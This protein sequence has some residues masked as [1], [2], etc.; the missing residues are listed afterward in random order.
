MD[1]NQ[2]KKYE[3]LIHERDT[4]Q[5]VFC[6]APDCPGFLGS[7]LSFVENNERRAKCPECN[8]SICVICRNAA[9]VGECVIGEF[10]KVMNRLGIRQ[11]PRCG[12]A[13]IK[14]GGCSHMHCK[15]CG[16]HYTWQKDGGMAEW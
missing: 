10:A 9:H 2:A 5:P 11:C 6:I 13:T 14:D 15:G 12:Y 3:K 4:P 16:S 1:E 8:I 7:L